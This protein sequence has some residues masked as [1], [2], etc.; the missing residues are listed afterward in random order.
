[1]KS[2]MAKGGCRDGLLRHFTLNYF[3]G[4]VAANRGINHKI[5]QTSLTRFIQSK[6]DVFL[7]NWIFC[8]VLFLVVSETGDALVCMFITTF[9][10]NCGSYNFMIHLF[11]IRYVRVQMDVDAEYVL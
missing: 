7:L 9:D 4:L 5:G 3:S 6:C 10:K 8:T 11:I 2:A 1:M